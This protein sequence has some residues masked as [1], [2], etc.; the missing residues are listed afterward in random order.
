MSLCVSPYIGFQS[1]ENGSQVGNTSFLN[2]STRMGIPSQGVQRLFSHL[3]KLS[4]YIADL[5]L[6]RPL[7]QKGQMEKIIHT[8]RHHLQTSAL[9]QFFKALQKKT[10]PMAG[11]E[12]WGKKGWHLDTPKVKA[13]IAIYVRCNLPPHTQASS[14]L[15][16]PFLGIISTFDAF[17]NL[18]M[19]IDI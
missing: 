8:S 9:H 1:G 19:M 16:C 5:N 18:R 4:D 7:F 12:K 17:H 6:Q 10:T 15:K 2:P 11:E 13:T 14:F 3:S